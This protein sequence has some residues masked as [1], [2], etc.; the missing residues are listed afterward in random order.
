MT[1]LLSYCAFAGSSYTW[2]CPNAGAPPTG[3]SYSVDLVSGTPCHV[4]AL[5]CGTLASNS[6]AAGECENGAL[7]ACAFTSSVRRP[8]HAKCGRLSQPGR[9]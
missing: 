9:H 1:G 6:C 7:S 3:V 2:Y 4:S 5:S 8:L